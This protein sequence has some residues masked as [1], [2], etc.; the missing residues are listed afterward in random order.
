MN[1]QTRSAVHDHASLLRQRS[2]SRFQDEC[3]LNG[4]SIYGQITVGLALYLYG[5]V[6]TPGYFSVLL[7]GLYLLLSCLLAYPLAR[8]AGQEENVL[9]WAAGKR[10]GKALSLFMAGVF[11]LDAL[12]AFLALCAIVENIL[13]NVSAL[14]TSLLI[15]GLSALALNGRNPRALASLSRPLRWGILGAMLYCAAAALPHG[16][17]GHLFPW[18]GWGPDRIL[19]GGGWMCG[20]AAAGCAP[21][22]LPRSAPGERG[23]IGRKALLLPALAAVLLGASAALFS[24]WLMPVYALARPES[25]GWRMLLISN[26][27]PSVLG[28]S[29]EVIALMFLMLLTL[30]AG[31]QRAAFCIAWTAG[32]ASPSSLLIAVLAL[33]LVPSG[34]LRIKVIEDA[35]RMLAPWRAAA[36]A[37]V[38]L[39]LWTG[40][41]TRRKIKLFGKKASA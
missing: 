37:L 7:S 25:L 26:M 3:A 10:L 22:L 18:L 39:A 28:W 21:L 27:S 41:L 40:A 11:L 38:L 12:L 14:W 23:S 35:L 2:L 24:A 15:G 20:C 29:L 32:K 31:L 16:N 34:A 5:F 19:L 4:V 1:S 17:P 33:L 13:P 30:S 6:S 9:S 36:M 8:R